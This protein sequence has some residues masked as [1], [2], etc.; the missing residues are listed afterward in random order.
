MKRTALLVATPLAGG[1]AILMANATSA[2]AQPG[3]DAEALFKERCATCHEPATERAPTRADMAQRP[4]AQLVDIMTNGPMAPMA[5]GL[6]AGQIQALAAHLGVKPVT[7]PPPETPARGGVP[8][9]AAGGRGRGGGAEAADGAQRPSTYNPKLTEV[10]CATHPAIAMTPTSWSSWGIDERNTRFQRNPGLKASDVPKLKVKWAFSY[11]GGSYGQPIVVGDHLFMT[12]RGGTMYALDAK[13]GCVHWKVEN[14]VSRTTPMVVKSDLSPSGWVT[15]VGDR[16]RVVHAI[17]AST[18]KTIWKSGVLDDHRSAGITGSPIYY[19][20]QLFVPLTS[21]EEGAGTAPNYQCCSFRGSLV[22]LDAKSGQ[23]QWK[24]Y[25]ITEPLRPIRKNSAGTQLQGPAGGAIWSAPTIDPK[26]GLVLVATGDSYIDAPTTGA[27]AIIAYDIKTGKEKWRNQVTENDDFIVGCTRV[28]K[29][30]NCSAKPGPDYDFG[31]PPIVMKLKN[32][33]DVVISG[34]KSG[35]VYGMDPDTGKL[36]WKTQVG[37]GSSLGGVEWGM[38]ADDTYV[39]VPNSDLVALMEVQ[40]R[41]QGKPSLDD[42][43][44][45]VPKPGLTAINPAN[46]KVAWHVAGVKSPCK[47]FGDRSRDRAIGCFE[48][49]SAAATVIP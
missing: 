38:A 34:Q 46:G 42:R 9:A 49:H 21:G 16:T 43:F 8:A 29:P 37:N 26:R 25:V 40:N 33:K 18:G 48:A 1:L 20:G 6:S 2:P 35:I 3:I 36:L 15:F 41:A 47:W 22:A 12:S 14:L 11:P 13:S 24:Q 23:Q 39:Y 45:V 19:N 10:A 32:G 17:D 28:Q 5:A 30:I 7:A 27:D 4:V 31:S 44:H